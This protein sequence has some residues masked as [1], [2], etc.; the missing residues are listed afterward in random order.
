[1]SKLNFF[2][3]NKITWIHLISNYGSKY[4]IQ[5]EEILLF[6]ITYSNEKW[7]ITILFISHNYHII[8]VTNI[9]R[10]YKNSVIYSGREEKHASH[11]C[12]YTS[13]YIS[14]IYSSV[15]IWIKLLLFIKYAFACPTSKMT[16][17]NIV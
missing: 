7:A 16:S 2:L 9:Y 3:V 6:N 5:K 10:L 11:I 15:H 8:I 4:N 13:H 14:H 17:E 1:M 12:L